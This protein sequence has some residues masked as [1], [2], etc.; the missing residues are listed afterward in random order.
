MAKSRYE[1][2]RLFE[3]ADALLPNTFLVVRIDG[4]AFTNFTSD[5]AFR[6]PNDPRGLSLMNAAARAVMDQFSDVFLAYGQSDE[7]SFVFARGTKLWGRRASKLTTAVVSLFTAT[8]VM[9]WPEYMIEEAMASAVGVGDNVGGGSSFRPMPLLRAPQFDGR[10]VCYPSSQNLMDYMCWRQVDCHIN[11]LYNTTFWALVKK[12][13]KTEKE[14]HACLSGTVSS[15][16]NEMLFTD[17][18]INYNDEPNIYRKGSI[19][20]RKKIEVVVTRKAVLKQGGG[21]AAEKKVKKQRK[22]V[23]LCHEDMTKTAFWASEGL[24]QHVG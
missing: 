8:Y 16:K 3:Q 10:I 6:K 14:A 17:F 18:G 11:N 2:V 1:Y 12:G 19:M 15:Q 5:H 24:G 13:N 7:Y 22:V 4:R 9:K 23:E 20:R 21:E